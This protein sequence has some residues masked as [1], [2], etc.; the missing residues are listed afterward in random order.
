MTTATRENFS[1]IVRFVF[2]SPWKR[3]ALLDRPPLPLQ[4]CDSFIVGLHQSRS[5]AAAPRPW[6]DLR[7]RPLH[8]WMHLEALA[9]NRAPEYGRRKDRQQECNADA[10]GALRCLR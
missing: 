6:L 9:D 4:S 2:F 10:C 5:D 8:S 7:S 1:S 3:A